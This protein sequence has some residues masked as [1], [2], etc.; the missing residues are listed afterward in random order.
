[1]SAEAATA[2]WNLD[3]E[4]QV[5]DFILVGNNADSGTWVGEN[6]NG[7]IRVT[8]AQAS[9]GAAI[10]FPDFDEGLVVK[11]FEFEV[12]VRLGDGTNPPADG[13]SINY[14]SADDPAI[15]SIIAGN[16][17]VW[18]GTTDINGTETSLPEE[19]TRTGLA[20]GF[21]TW[22]FPGGENSDVAGSDLRG[23]SIR[24]DGVLIHQ[25]PLPSVGSATD[26]DDPN[27]LETGPWSAANTGTGGTGENLTWQPLRVQLHEDGRLDVSWK[28]NPVLENFDA[29]AFFPRPG[30]LVFGGRTGGSFA[31]QD[32]D[33][34]RI[35]TVPA[36]TFLISGL[37]GNASGFTVTVND[38]Q[39]STLDPSSVQLFL[40]DE[41]V[42]FTIT[43]AGAVNSIRHDT[44]PNWLPAGSTNEVRIVASDNNNIEAELIRSFV[45]R[46]YVILEPDWRAPAG[47]WDTSAPGYTGFIHQL[48]VA[49]GPG[50][51][52]SVHNAARQLAGGFLDPVSGQPYPNLVDPS[53]GVNADGT[54][55]Q[56]DNFLS[57]DEFFNWNQDAAT[58]Q[59]GSFTTL[60]GS[61]YPDALIPGIPGTTGSTDNIAMEAYSYL[62][63]EGGK[64]YTLV[65]NSDDGFRVTAGP[66]IRSVLT[67]N[68]LGQFDDG[69]GFSDVQF[70][71]VVNESGVYRLR[72]T[73]WEGGGGAG[74]E[75][76]HLLEDGSKVMFNDPYHAEAV[77]S[78]KPSSTP[79]P[80]APAL[81]SVA[82]YP[83][84]GAVLAASPVQVIF[85][86]GTTATV[87]AA[88]VEVRVNGELLPQTADAT[89]E[90]VRITA[91][92][93]GP[94]TPGANNVVVTWSDSTGANHEDSWSFTVAPYETLP[95]WLA[96]PVGSGTE[97]GLTAKLH[98]VDSIADAARIPNR[99]HVRD[100]QLEGL[101][102]ETVAT[103]PATP[104]GISV[105][106]YWDQ[107]D[108]PTR[109]FFNPDNGF[110]DATFPGIPGTPTDT[111]RARDDFAMEIVAYIEFPNPGF[112]V[113]GVNSDDGFRIIAREKWERLPLRIE[114]PQSIAGWVGSVSAGPESGQGA[115]PLPLPAITAEVVLADPPLG[116]AALV[117]AEAINGKIALLRRGGGITFNDKISR[118]RQAGA[119]AVIISNNGTDAAA[120]GR[121]PIEMTGIGAENNAIPAVMIMQ[122]T[123]AAIESALAQGPVTV[124]LGRDTIPTIGEVNAGRGTAE[125]VV[126]FQV[127]QAGLYPFRLVYFEGG[128]GATLE[129]YMIGPG[130]VRALIND[131]ANPT[132]GLRAFRSAPPVEEPT[133]LE[134]NQPT[135]AE[136]QITLTW[137]GTG[138]L[139]EATVIDGQWTPVDPQPSGGTYTTPTTG[140]AKYFRLVQ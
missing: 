12:D 46:R 55:L 39:G 101:F 99:W 81:V 136:G 93:D 124:S 79:Q 130:N 32:I 47:S 114:S 44:A 82:P 28:G 31:Y 40:N 74:L 7:F 71:V 127:N 72:L 8:A 15:A 116:E 112:Y 75:F 34:I 53:N 69:K 5:D 85:R 38:A 67:T 61:G 83:N 102:G 62:E 132:V 41:P 118:A 51:A 3:E 135:L 30:R 120:P 73:W 115:G 64:L 24:I 139:E 111:G 91:Q 138:T 33:N 50:N 77:R 110:P 22:G 49:R 122:S 27:S 121:L 119:I 4:S 43:T 97:P 57:F 131:S 68:W 14:A 23:I 37:R 59:G 104:T 10:L 105:V 17:G 36:T 128:G 70:D 95:E 80:F 42:D 45:V 65:V 126:G 29:S 1:M 92:K 63:L 109:G 9:R 66:E 2:E 54:F 137:E 25:E 125:S 140:D 20:I 100:A 16:T 107:Q 87:A 56:P 18:A 11:A 96:R 60:T 88:N 98:Q 78:Y 52:N 86:N 26:P 103:V 89:G 133:E 6:G 134:F 76:F 117:N 58:A 129:W 84:Q 90:H 94:L 106:N 123:G 21:D 48:P 113:M 35:T 108:N 13:F 19:G